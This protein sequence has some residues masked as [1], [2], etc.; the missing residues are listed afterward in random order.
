MT[1]KW[2][3]KNETQ[4]LKCYDISQHK[5]SH[6]SSSCPHFI[7]IVVTLIVGRAFSRDVFTRG[8]RDL[9]KKVVNSTVLNDPL[10][11]RVY[12]SRD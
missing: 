2:N 5:M 9:K 8:G 12:V 10:Q 4:T 1:K 3:H 6:C 7:D 11:K